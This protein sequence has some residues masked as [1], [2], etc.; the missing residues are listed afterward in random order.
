LASCACCATCSKMI[1]PVTYGPSQES[2]CPT[3]LGAECKCGKHAPCGLNL[4]PSLKPTCSLQSQLLQRVRLQA[5]TTG[6]VQNGALKIPASCR[7]VAA[8]Q[9]H[10]TRTMMLS[11]LQLHS[12][13]W[14][15]QENRNAHPSSALKLQRQ[16][17]ALLWWLDMRRNFQNRRSDMRNEFHL[18][19]NHSCS[20]QDGID[21]PTHRGC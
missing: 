2:L 7:G 3:P 15:T 17:L 9:S 20:C 5:E 14:S 10:P 8:T 6:P 11:C 16:S 18:P 12:A 4:T 13:A 19:S 21:C 1:A